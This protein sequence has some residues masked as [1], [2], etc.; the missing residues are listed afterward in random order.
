MNN[1]I[2]ISSHFHILKIFSKY[3][4]WTQSLK[5]KQ[6]QFLFQIVLSNSKLQLVNFALFNTPN[7]KTIQFGNKCAKIRFKQKRY[8][9]NEINY[10]KLQAIIGTNPDVIIIYS[11][12]HL[13]SS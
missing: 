5:A 9:D 4:K 7:R 13:C 11:T 1:K 2:I 6:T 8:N 12:K 3:E 10:V